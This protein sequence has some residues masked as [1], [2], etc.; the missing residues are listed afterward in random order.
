MAY[1][2]IINCDYTGQGN[3]SLGKLKCRAS[4]TITIPET[5]ESEEWLKH[6]VVVAGTAPSLIP[7]MLTTDVGFANFTNSTLTVMNTRVVTYADNDETVKDDAWN[8]TVASGDTYHSVAVARSGYFVATQDLESETTTFLLVNDNGK[9]VPFTYWALPT[10]YSRIPIENGYLTTYCNGGYASGVPEGTEQRKEYDEPD[11]LDNEIT[12]HNT[13]MDSVPE[14]GVPNYNDDSGDSVTISQ[15][16]SPASA[17]GIQYNL[18]NTADVNTFFNW[19]WND[20]FKAESVTDFIF[21][22]VSHLYGDLSKCILGL[23]YSPIPLDNCITG[24]IARNIQLGRFTTPTSAVPPNDAIVH[25]LIQTTG[26]VTGLN[27]NFLD[28]APYTQAMW[29]LPFYGLA[30]CDINK[31]LNR[32]LNFKL[33]FDIRTG[34]ARWLIINKAN[35]VPMDMYDFQ[36]AI[37]QPITL[38]DGGRITQSIADAVANTVPSAPVQAVAQVV[39]NGVPGSGGLSVQSAVGSL[40]HTLCAKAIYVIRVTPQYYLPNNMKNLLGRMCNETYKVSE[41]KGFCQFKNIKI[42]YGKTKN[43][44]NV[45]VYPTSNEMDEIVSLLE[46]GIL[47]EEV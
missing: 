3:G 29:Y 20:I 41:L 37:E 24:S 27:N 19:Y 35:G 32:E 8:D 44:D 33:Y 31:Y 18:M 39:G 2:L 17:G 15:Q 43:S 7:T 34:L 9:G 30:P 11:I 10:T 28:N 40:L 12:E 47:L 38:D 25:P 14:E 4:S 46:N 16:G 13:I 1:T 6:F 42:N 23:K 22:S 5:V 21:N 45:K 26:K 36:L